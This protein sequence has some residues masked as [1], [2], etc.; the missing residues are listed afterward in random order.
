MLPLLP[1]DVIRFDS[2]TSIYLFICLF[3]SL[4]VCSLQYLP[5]I[6]IYP[7]SIHTSSTCVFYPSLYHPSIQPSHYSS[8]VCVYVNIKVWM[9]SWHHGNV[10]FWLNYLCLMDGAG[11]SEGD[12]CALN[13]SLLN[14]LI[15]LTLLGCWDLAVSVRMCCFPSEQFFFPLVHAVEA[16]LHWGA[17]LEAVGKKTQAA[18]AKQ[19]TSGQQRLMT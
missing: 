13:A 4:S 17:C 3:G 15:L 16:A 2:T 7:P 18:C 14:S 9:W 19:P 8:V 6:I 10:T 5:S 11:G 12:V 1:Q